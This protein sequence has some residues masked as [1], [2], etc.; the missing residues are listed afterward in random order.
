MN[1]YRLNNLINELDSEK[2]ADLL[3]YYL[4]KRKELVETISSEIKRK[5]KRL[6][7]LLIMLPSV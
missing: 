1:L 2:D 3:N 5:L 7:N 6:Q 4:K